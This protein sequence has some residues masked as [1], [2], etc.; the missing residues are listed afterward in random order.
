MLTPIVGM[1]RKDLQI[2]L[3]D[4]RAVI[5]AFV[6]PIAIASFFGSIFSGGGSTEAARIPIAVVDQD[7][8]AHL[9]G[10]RRARL[11]RHEPA[12]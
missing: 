12:S 6:V 8:S 2:F 7:G 9:E 11:D 4:R 3:S 10:D 5:M 1:V